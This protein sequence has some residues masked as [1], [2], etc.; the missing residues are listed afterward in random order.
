MFYVFDGSGDMFGVIGDSGLRDSSICWNN[1][2]M[3]DISSHIGIYYELFL[4]LSYL[5]F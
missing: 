1:N 2:T 4:L 3:C 5:I